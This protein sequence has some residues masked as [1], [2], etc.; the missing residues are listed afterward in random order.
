MIL[1][2]KVKKGDYYII[3]DI[4]NQKI[5][6]IGLVNKKLDENLYEIKINNIN[7][8]SYMNL[9][10]LPVGEKFFKIEKRDILSIIKMM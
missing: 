1:L 9:T 10:N 3:K 5:Y 4:H 6:L 2:K 7:S 8:S